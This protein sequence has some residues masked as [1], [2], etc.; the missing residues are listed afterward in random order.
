M[1]RRLLLLCLLAL[2]LPLPAVDE[3][4]VADGA[5]IRGYDAVA[6]HRGQGAVRGDLAFAWRWNGALWL[7]ASAGHRD[8]FAADPARYAPQYG[9]YCAYGLSQGYKVGIDPEAFAIV[10]G[11]LYLNYSKAVQQTWN[12]DRGG[13]IRL[14]D[15]H[16]RRL[17]DQPY[18]APS[19]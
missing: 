6:Y 18:E 5:A 9:G 19:R 10:D 8:D 14:A 17:A 1:T 11:R 2:S 13:Y 15:G 12:A 3:V 16:W 7:F 4:F